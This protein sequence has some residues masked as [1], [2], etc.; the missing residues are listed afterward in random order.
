MGIGRVESLQVKT[1]QVVE[2]AGKKLCDLLVRSDP[3]GG[4]DCGREKCYPCLTKSIS[5]K[6]QP[7]WRKNL[8]NTAVC[9]RC[10]DEGVEAVYHGESGKSLYQRTQWHIDKLRAFDS[11]SFLLRHNLLYHEEDDPKCP[12]APQWPSRSCGRRSR[13]PAAP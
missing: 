13:C 7:C 3:F 1:R 5:L 6:W 2:R 11:G 8:T 9:L 12:A 4:G 10:K